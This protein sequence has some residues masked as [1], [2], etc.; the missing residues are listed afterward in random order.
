MARTAKKTAEK[1]KPSRTAAQKAATARM[2]AANKSRRSGNSTTSAKPKKR[3]S[4]K[5]SATPARKVVYRRNPIGGKKND[6]VN[7]LLHDIAIPAGVGAVGALAVDAVWGNLKFISMETRTGKMKHLGKAALGVGIA[8][9][10]GKVESLKKYGM[11]A[12]IG[13]LTVQAHEIAFKKITEDFPKV[14]LAGYDEDELN[15]VIEELNGLGEGMALP[16]PGLG[17]G[18]ALGFYEP[19][20]A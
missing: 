8:M 6:L 3:R 12:A 5:R 19:S 15:A 2:I 16:E 4:Y 10:A 14:G 13:A 11:Q 9:L 7:E 17:D 1:R 18:A 20:Y